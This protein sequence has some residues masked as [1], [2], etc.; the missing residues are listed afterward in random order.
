MSENAQDER[1][2]RH[3]LDFN[4]RDTGHDAAQLTAAPGVEVNK[5]SAATSRRPAHPTPTAIPCA[6]ALGT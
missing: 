5:Q 2:E 6:I 3:F 1:C 4:P